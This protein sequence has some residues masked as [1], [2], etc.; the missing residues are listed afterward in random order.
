MLRLHFPNRQTADVPLADGVCPVV[1]HASGQIL[2]GVNAVG[3]LLL[4]RF[5]VDGRG[6]WLQV[7][8]DG[9][10]VH[11]NGRPVRRMAWVRAG[12][13]VNVDGQDIHVLGRHEHALPT[14]APAQAVLRA[15]GG[16]LHGRAFA[17]HRGWVMGSS[18]EADIVLADATLPPLFLRIHPADGQVQLQ[19][20]ASGGEV[21]LNGEPVRQAQVMPGDQLTLP[22]NLRFALEAPDAGMPA[23]KAEQALAQSAPSVETRAAAPRPGGQGTTWPWLLLAAFGL[24]GLLAALLLFGP[25]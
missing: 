20:L 10:R 11:V 14:G 13:Q 8:D 2:A 12:D 16:P 19:V 5:C 18:Q 17:L 9:S 1:R 7:S 4:A 23:W 15:H 25:R 6:I 3:M 24:A 22:G 21:L